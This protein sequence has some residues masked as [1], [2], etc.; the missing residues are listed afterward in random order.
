MATA[1]LL[2]LALG[3]ITL[4]LVLRGEK[5]M[6]RYLK[7]AEGEE[8][9]ARVLALLPSNYAVFHG[10]RGPS[11]SGGSDFDHVVIGPTGVFLIETK[12][13]TG[14]VRLNGDDLLYE[15]HDGRSSDSTMR[16]ADRPPL[17]Q[18]REA[19]RALELRLKGG[20]VLKGEVQPVL[21]FASNVFS[22]GAAGV[23]GVMVCNADRLSRMLT[24]SL[25]SPLEDRE[26]RA[27]ELFLKTWVTP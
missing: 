12:N 17:D 22:V 26:V 25:E 7:G 15:H 23:G 19:S 5:N 18:V 14:T 13:W 16:Q 6:K 10:L 3:V 11:G 20:E 4:S 2:L 24:E 8:R 9:M 21:C 1:G 27:L